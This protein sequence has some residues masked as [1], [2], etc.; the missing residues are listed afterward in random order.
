MELQE[1]TDLLVLQGLLEHLV[2]QDLVELQEQT[3]LLVLQG[4]L[5]H[6][7]LQE[8][9]E[10]QVLQGHQEP[11]EQAQQGLQPQRLT[12]IILV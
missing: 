12:L 11:V 1:Q 6:L 7:V 8:Q 5:G 3:D 9:T 10:H 2:L 4:L